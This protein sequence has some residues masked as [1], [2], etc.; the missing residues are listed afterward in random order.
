MARAGNDMVI[1]LP[2]NYVTLNGNG[3]TDD[4][5]I[6]LLG[7]FWLAG[8]TLYFLTLHS[9]KVVLLFCKLFA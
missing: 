8:R 2:V 1:V 4:K 9:L 6:K 3:S 7:S 5:V